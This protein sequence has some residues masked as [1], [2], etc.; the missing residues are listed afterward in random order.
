MKAKESADTLE[1]TMDLIQ[2]YA[3]AAYRLELCYGST[4]KVTATYPSGMGESTKIL[5]EG[6]NVDMTIN[7]ALYALLKLVGKLN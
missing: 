2:E 6:P 1:R 7:E 4:W 3:P 5:A